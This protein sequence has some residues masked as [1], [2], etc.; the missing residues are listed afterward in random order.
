MSDSRLRVAGACGPAMTVSRSNS[1][2]Y[3]FARNKGT[4]FNT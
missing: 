2:G 3:L 1:I 4:F